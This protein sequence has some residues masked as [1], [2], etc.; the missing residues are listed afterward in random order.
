MINAL[1]VYKACLRYV[2]REHTGKKTTYLDELERVGRRLFGSKFHGV[3]PANRIPKLSDRSPYC[4]LN[5]DNEGEAGSHWVALVKRAGD[6]GCVFYDSFGRRHT[7]ILDNLP[8]SGNGKIID[9][10]DDREQGLLES[11]CGARCMAFIMVFVL[12]GEKEALTI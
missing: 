4:I 10:E 1:Q 8:L 2:E 7:E 5:L 12:L 6:K 11:N 9:T 3:Y